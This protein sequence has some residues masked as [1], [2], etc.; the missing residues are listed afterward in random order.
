MAPT[1]I[2][3]SNTTDQHFDITILFNVDERSGNYVFEDEI[4]SQPSD[5]EL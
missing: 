3:S 2:I 1:P 4:P 5:Q